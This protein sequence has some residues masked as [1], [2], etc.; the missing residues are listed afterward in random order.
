MMATIVE[1]AVQAGTFSTLV[2]AV[3]AAGLVEALSEPGP[4]TVF[5]PTD[6]AFAE[7]PEGTL[8]QL[9]ED[10]PQLTAIL[11]YHVVPGRFVA[12]DVMEMHTAMTLL[13][14]ELAFDSSEGVRVNDAYVSQADI[15]CDNGVIHVIDG[16]L[17]PE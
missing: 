5:A 13:G 10:I 17:L 7:L 11:K 1:T 16:V 14:K 3:Q 15:A 4:Y 6:E 12:A 2:A 8:E 9:L